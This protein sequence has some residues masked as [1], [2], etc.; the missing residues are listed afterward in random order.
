MLQP[1]GLKT[2]QPLFSQ[3]SSTNP[4]PEAAKHS[5]EERIKRKQ[6]VDTQFRKVKRLRRAD[7]SLEEKEIEECRQGG[8]VRNQPHDMS[9][10]V[11]LPLKTDPSQIGPN[12]HSQVQIP[13]ETGRIFKLTKFYKEDFPKGSEEA[14]TKEK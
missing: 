8:E 11:G 2:A 1:N 3:P 9:N 6:P 12:F 14:Q 4:S 13:E 10:R 7:D 5:V